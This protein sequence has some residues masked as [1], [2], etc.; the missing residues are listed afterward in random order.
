MKKPFFFKL[1]VVIIVEESLEATNRSWTAT[2]KLKYLFLPAEVCMVSGVGIMK[3]TL[4]IVM[5]CHF[6]A[7]CLWIFYIISMHVC[8]VFI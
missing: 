3:C 1:D 8:Y 2:P 6:E 4:H 5:K 7:P